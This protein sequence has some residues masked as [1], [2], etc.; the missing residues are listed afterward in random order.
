MAL[1]VWGWGLGVSSMFRSI[2]YWLR[3]V[4]KARGKSKRKKGAGLGQSEW[5]GK[6]QKG[7][8]EEGEWGKRRAMGRAAARRQQVKVQAQWAQVMELRRVRREGER[9]VV[10]NGEGE[11]EKCRGGERGECRGGGRGVD[12][13]MD[14]EKDEIWEGEEGAVEVVEIRG[15]ECGGNGKKKFGRVAVG[16]GGVEVEVAEARAMADCVWNLGR[17]WWFWKMCFVKNEMYL[18]QGRQR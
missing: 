18:I 13:E 5:R 9:L 2:V 3:K 4:R 15:G 14:M 1:E 17:W 11:M 8:T 6:D 12:A 16:D 10:E 7:G